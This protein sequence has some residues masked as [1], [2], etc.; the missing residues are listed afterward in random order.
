[1][2]KIKFVGLSHNPPGFPQKMS[3]KHS[4]SYALYHSEYF[5]VSVINENILCLLYIHQ[6]SQ[7]VS[8]SSDIKEYILEYEP[9]E[10]ETV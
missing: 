10:N 7:F 9:T 3:I 8:V 6:V 5:V 1:M 2:L 4:D